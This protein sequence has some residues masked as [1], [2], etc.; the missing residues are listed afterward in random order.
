MSGLT[1][2]CAG[3]ARVPLEHDDAQA[4]ATGLVRVREADHPCAHNA[5]VGLD[6]SCEG[7][8]E[9]WAKAMIS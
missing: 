2:A 1:D 9:S 8:Q 7:R 5:Y 4:A 3:R 6:R